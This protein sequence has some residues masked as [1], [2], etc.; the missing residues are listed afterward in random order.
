YPHPQNFLEVLF[1]SDSPYNYGGYSSPRADAL[2][3]TAGSESDTAKSLQI[4][5]QVEQI[6]VDEAACIPLWFGKS[7]VLTKP[8]I[9]G[10]NPTAMGW[11]KLTT[12]STSK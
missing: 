11:A 10:Y 3:D 6:M 2:L 9:K 5:Q 4:Y 7:Y 8:Y 12:V 1:R